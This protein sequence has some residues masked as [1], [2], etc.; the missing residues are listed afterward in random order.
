M[1]EIE[2]TFLV[3]TLPLGFEN[4]LQKEMLDIYIP[5]SS[6][7]PVLRVRKSGD[8]YEITKKEPISGND[9]SYQLET[10]IPLNVEEFEYVQ[11]LPGKRVEKTRYF[12]EEFGT[13]YEIDVFGGSLKGLV[14]AD[15]EFGSLKARDAFS[16]PD[17]CLADVTQ[18]KYI[19]GGVL[20]GKHYSDIEEKLKSFG[21]KKL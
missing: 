2:L 5:A 1:E 13:Q 18:E 10:T 4:S 9:S 11:L 20:A 3:K 16:M 19:A 6:E 7:H 17:W 8:V 14:L 21:Y 15:V 12:Y